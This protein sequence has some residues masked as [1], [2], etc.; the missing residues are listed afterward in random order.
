MARQAAMDISVVK[1]E[2][3]LVESFDSY[4][5]TNKNKSISTEFSVTK[6]N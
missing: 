1:N 4:C 6:V 3:D 5:E 2:I